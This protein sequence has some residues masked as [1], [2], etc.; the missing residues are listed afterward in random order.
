MTG[1]SDVQPTAK[2]IARWT[3]VATISVILPLLAVLELRSGNRALS[4]TLFAVGIFGLA[5]TAVVVAA[6]RGR[7]TR[8]LPVVV[9]TIV[10]GVW[11]IYRGL[12]ANDTRTG[13]IY[14]GF[15]ASFVALVVL[16]A[17]VRW[18]RER[19]WVVDS[20]WRRRL[21]FSILMAMVGRS[22]L[23]LDYL[24]LTWGLIV[25]MFATMFWPSRKRA[26]QP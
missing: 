3:V 19:G 25:A 5:I 21:S 12:A 7:F 24:V 11:S 26:I 20:P 10:G 13:E 18:V 2:W 22:M 9:S 17:A 16:G 1:T 6:A 8:F 15:A 14:R 4:I 23:H